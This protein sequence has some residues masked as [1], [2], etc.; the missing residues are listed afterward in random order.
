MGLVLDVLGVVEH[1]PV[2]RDADP[3]DGVDAVAQYKRLVVAV[4]MAHANGRSLQAGPG[5]M[6]D[7]VLQ[8]SPGAER[9]Q[10][11]LNDIVEKF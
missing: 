9:E 2:L 3:A 8:K 1:G 4:D 5:T 10:T 6:V 11:S 7:F